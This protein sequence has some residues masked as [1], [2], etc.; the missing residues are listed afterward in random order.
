MN[1]TRR[2]HLVYLGAAGMAVAAGSP[3]IADGHGANEVQ[4]LN[5]HPEDR[6]QNMVFVP[7]LIHVQPGD[8]IKFVSA[9]RGHNVQTDEDMSPE[10]GTAFESAINE[11]VEVTFDVEGAYGIYCT[12][13][14][15]AGMVGLILVGNALENYEDLKDVRQRGQAK[16]R[17]EALFERADTMVEE[18]RANA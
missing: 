18:I 9:D 12:P 8:A 3:L 5:K 15:S 17:W 6:R 14:R 1:I 13:H 2:Q 16:K 10:G 7:D 4:M 11:D